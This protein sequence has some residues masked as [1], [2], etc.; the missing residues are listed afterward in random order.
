M[1]VSKLVVVVC[2]LGWLATPQRVAG[3]P[4]APRRIVIAASTPLDGRG[5]V[6]R[7]TRIVVEGGRIAAIDPNPGLQADIIAVAG[8]PRKDITAV[9]RVSFVMKGGVVHKNA[10]QP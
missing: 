9:R 4:A 3:Q 8:D 1:R 2:M 5:H 6:L 10:R 7:N